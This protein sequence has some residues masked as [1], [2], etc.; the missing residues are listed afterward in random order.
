MDNS[1]SLLEKK[2]TR[3]IAARKEAEALLEQKSYEL[4]VKNKQ[5]SVAVQQLEKQSQIDLVKIEFEND[6]D[7]L[8]IRYG[9]EFLH[10]TLDDTLLSI[11]LTQLHQNSVILSIYFSFDRQQSDGS[12]TQH[13]F[14]NKELL[15]FQ[16]SSDS[17]SWSEDCFCCRLQIARRKV[18]FLI[19]RVSL[20]QVDKPCV[21]K[22]LKLI[23]EL[24]RGVIGREIIMQENELSR[25][26]AQ[27]SERAT[28]E[29]VAMINHELRTPLLGLLGSAELLSGTL[30][31]E[32]QQQY[33]NNIRYSGDMLRYIINDMLDFSKMNS[34]MMQLANQRFSW[35]DVE[36]TLQGIFTQK[37]QE[38]RLNFIIDARA[39]AL[40][41]WM[42]DLERV[43]QIVVNLVGNAIKFTQYGDV[44]VRAQW[45]Q[46]QLIIEVLDTGIGIPQR[47]RSS[48]FDPFVQAD[49]S[50]KR[51]FEG[52]GLGLAIC[53][54]LVELM[55]GTLTFE[56]EEGRG[57]SFTVA[58]PLVLVDKLDS[59]LTL[60]NADISLERE[61]RNKR[62]LVVDDITMNQIIIKQMLQNIDIYPDVCSNGQ[63][64][65]DQ[66]AKQRYDLVFM[67]CRMPIMD[68]FEATIRLRELNI[69]IP[70]IALTA[71]TTLEEKNQCE[72]CG[73]D[74]ILH[75]PYTMKE[76][77]AVLDQWL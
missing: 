73:M 2:I 24:L 65:L 4:Y 50:S 3:A 27:A 41:V 76:L 16:Q 37:A 48:L 14:G 30:L 40:Y 6:I 36:N 35:Q 66:L 46:A 26:K 71:G 11:F 56:S 31:N 18:G 5:L 15:I 9:S 1:N 63:E 60:V 57:T 43:N 25:K 45:H 64:A 23:G 13:E 33:L 52:V 75:K 54:N 21:E 70:I 72:Q 55:G 74:S 62:V 8:L 58:L 38:K 59:E 39:L 77:K 47:A 7:A 49:R 17:E 29:F 20:D 51:A 61:Y 42:G 19:Y 69:K 67:D 53:K 28:K 44:T 10:H 34:G 32:N 68:G 22:K 12:I